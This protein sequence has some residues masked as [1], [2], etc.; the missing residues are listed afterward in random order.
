M[1]PCF[2]K[3]LVRM[4]IPAV[5]KYHWFL[6]VH[7]NLLWL[8]TI[9]ENE[10][11][12]WT[13]GSHFNRIP[14]EI[15]KIELGF[16]LFTFLVVLTLCIPYQNKESEENTF[17]FGSSKSERVLGTNFFI[18]SPSWLLGHL[19]SLCNERKK[20]RKERRKGQR[21]ENKKK[22]KKKRKERKASYQ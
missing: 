13:P 12:Q 8:K 3:H 15:Q 7:W 18:R 11:I 16:S 6:K 1:C 20:E 17:D 14:N 2:R 10:N 22:K 21:K 19:H 4:F 5:L 9:Q